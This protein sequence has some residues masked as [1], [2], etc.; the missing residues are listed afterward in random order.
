MAA[1]ALAT[2]ILAFA[3]NAAAGDFDELAL[4]LFERQFE[5]I[6]FYREHCAAIG[7]SPASVRRWSEIPAIETPPELEAGVEARGAA[8]TSPARDLARSVVPLALPELFEPSRLRLLVGSGAAPSGAATLIG[9]LEHDAPDDSLIAG[10]RLDAKRLRSWLGARQR[11]RRPV[12][13]ASDPEGF[14]KLVSVLER[15]AVKFRL[16]PGSEAFCVFGFEDGARDAARAWSQPLSSSLGL[17]GEACRRVL[18]ASG[19]STPLLEEPAPAAARLR[20]PHWVQLAPAGDGRLALLDLA[21]LEH[22]PRL[23]PAGSAFESS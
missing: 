14:E 11:D 1:D 17:A 7:A 5:T 6:L 13:V 22:P 3:R 16:P 20:L 2:R 12:L 4:A 19:S 23:L 15:R 18:S 9:A 8:S 10:N 21:S